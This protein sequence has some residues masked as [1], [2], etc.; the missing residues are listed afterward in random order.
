MPLRLAPLLALLVLAG[1][2]GGE[3]DRD[4]TLTIYASVPVSAAD[5][6]EEI[7]DFAIDL[8]TLPTADAAAPKPAEVAAAARTA[9]S[10]S[11]AVA[12][13]GEGERSASRTSAS[14]TNGARLLQVV[15]VGD[16]GELGSIEPSGDPNLGAA[17]SARQ[18]L[19]DVVAA[20]GAAED[21]GDREAVID[22]YLAGG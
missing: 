11:T 1:C 8:E 17:P 5:V 22:A 13:I 15:P 20:I 7:G 2:G 19:A 9:T 3:A 16:L 4:A 10:D 14:I 21:P 6:P 12:Y 18:A